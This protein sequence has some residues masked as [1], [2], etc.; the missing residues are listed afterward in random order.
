MVSRKPRRPQGTM[1]IPAHHSELE[2][3]FPENDPEAVSCGTEA[4][5][6][7]CCPHCGRPYFGPQAS[8]LLDLVILAHESLG[9]IK[10]VLE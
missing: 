1:A 2:L 6:P 8:R 7:A 9:K 4:G 3:G 10:A 5:G